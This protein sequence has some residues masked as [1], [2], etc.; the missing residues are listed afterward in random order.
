[1]EEKCS[2]DISIKSVIE[3]IRH[4]LLKY[5]L[6]WFLIGLLIIAFGAMYLLGVTT[7][8]IVLTKYSKSSK[9]YISK[10]IRKVPQSECDTAFLSLIINY[11]SQV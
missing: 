8:L 9:N 6:I 2:Y 4:F 1:M 5:K 10:L 7:T 11:Y 3:S